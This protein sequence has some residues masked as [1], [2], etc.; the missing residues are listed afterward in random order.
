M[1][2]EPTSTKN[3]RYS[4][5]KGHI[6][7]SIWFMAESRGHYIPRFYLSMCR[8]ER[9][10]HVGFPRYRTVHKFSLHFYT[11][12]NQ[13]YYLHIRS[14]SR[15]VLGLK[16]YRP[17]WILSFSTRMTME[18]LKICVIPYIFVII[19]HNNSDIRHRLYKPCKS[20]DF[21]YNWRNNSA[22]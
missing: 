11:R 1:Q 18:S 21:N 13:D 4:N 6:E 3:S 17:K 20:K 10:N 19:T 8:A 2:T 5:H 15:S 9:N 16:L 22:Y 7:A 12:Q 14:V